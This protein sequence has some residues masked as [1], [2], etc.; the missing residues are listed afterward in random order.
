MATTISRTVADLFDLANEKT[1]RLKGLPVL[2]SVV[3]EGLLADTR[4]IRMRPPFLSPEAK[5]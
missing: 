5:Q 4:W 3:L 2:F 1:G